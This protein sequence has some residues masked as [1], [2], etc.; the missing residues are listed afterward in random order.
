MFSDM[1]FKLVSPFC[2][3]T[4]SKQINY[5]IEANVIPDREFSIVFQ[6]SPLV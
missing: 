3:R 1:N 5:K 4:E 6:N 2:E